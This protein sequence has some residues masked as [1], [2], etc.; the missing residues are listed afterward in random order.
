MKISVTQLAGETQIA[1]V[2][3]DARPLRAGGSSSSRGPANPG[4]EVRWPFLLGAALTCC[5][6]ADV[7]NQTSP[8]AQ[9]TPLTLSGKAQQTDL[10]TRVIELNSMAVEK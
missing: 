4:G 5:L 10:E 9:R 7:P 1:I 3:T 6:R 8:A 2:S